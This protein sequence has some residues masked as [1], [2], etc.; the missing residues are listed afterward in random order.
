MGGGAVGETSKSKGEAG[1]LAA[2]GSFGVVVVV[3]A[4]QPGYSDA[5]NWVSD[6]IWERARH[7]YHC[8]CMLDFVQIDSREGGTIDTLSELLLRIL[9]IWFF[10]TENGRLSKILRKE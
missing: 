9:E 6:L 2:V 7:A 3:S 8:K 1:L 4:R 5:Y 10:D